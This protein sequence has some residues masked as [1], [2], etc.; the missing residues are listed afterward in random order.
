M[1]SRGGEGILWV[2]PGRGKHQFRIRQQHVQDHY[3]LLIKRKACGAVKLDLLLRCV[4]LLPQHAGGRPPGFVTDHWS[5]EDLHDLVKDDPE[6]RN[7]ARR[8]LKRTRHLKRKWVA[9]Q[10]E[11]LATENLV[12]VTPA[13]GSR[14]GI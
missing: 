2:G 3:V 10:L 14:P 5:Y 8:D 4:A 7:D 13:P 9:N 12:A 6:Q 1:P 11:K